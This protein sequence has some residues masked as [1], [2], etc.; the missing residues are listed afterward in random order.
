MGSVTVRW[1][2][3][4]P[5]PAAVAVFVGR[6]PD[7]RSS[8]LAWAFGVAPDTM[9]RHIRLLE[10][11]GLVKRQGHKLRLTVPPEVLHQRWGVS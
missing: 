6:N 10:L 11:A 8:D 3:I 1:E 5:V 2:G 9:R 7:T 4:T